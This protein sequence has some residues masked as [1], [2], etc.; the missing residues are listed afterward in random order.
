[1]RRHLHTDSGALATELLGTIQD[2]ENGSPSWART[3]QMRRH[4]HTGSRALPTELLG[5]MQDKENGSPSWARTSDKRINSPVLYQLS[6]WGIALSEVP[7]VNA[8]LR[9]GQAFFCRE[10]GFLIKA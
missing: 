5:N 3:R 8:L 1:M 2:K 7:Y 9:L 4:L 6:Y 10:E